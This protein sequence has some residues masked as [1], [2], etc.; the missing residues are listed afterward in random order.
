MAIAIRRCRGARLTTL[1]GRWTRD[2]IRNLRPPL[3][4]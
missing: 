1:D 4:G 3:Q 2:E